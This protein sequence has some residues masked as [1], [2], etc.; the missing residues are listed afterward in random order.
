MGGDEN[1]M[2]SIYNGSNGH[3]VGSLNNSGHG[4]RALPP[5]LVLPPGSSTMRPSSGQSISSPIYNGN[6][7]QSGHSTSLPSATTFGSASPQP[8]PSYANQQSPKRSNMGLTQS[9]DDFPTMTQMPPPMPRAWGGMGSFG[10]SSSSNGNNGGLGTSMSGL[11]ISAG[12]GIGGIQLPPPVPYGGGSGAYLAR[13]HQQSPVYARSVNMS[14]V[15]P[16]REEVND[17]STNGYGSQQ[18]G[19]G[20]GQGDSMVCPRFF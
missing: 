8:Q 13:L 19:H 1:A 20:Q 4:N 5:P 11:N 6:S 17:E 2:V 14:S 15:V 16:K 3:S 9:G 7:A 10:V 12:G 18:Q